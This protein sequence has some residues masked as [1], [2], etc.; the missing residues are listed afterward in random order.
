MINT[1]EHLYIIHIL[2]H[3]KYLI[4]KPIV[5]MVIISLYTPYYLVHNTSPHYFVDLKIL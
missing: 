5:L 4:D 1:V 3:K 2:Q